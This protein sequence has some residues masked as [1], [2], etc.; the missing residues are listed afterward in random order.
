MKNSS[1]RVTFT[2]GL[3]ALA[4]CGAAAAQ[5]NETPVEYTPLITQLAPIQNS[6]AL[7]GG[8]GAIQ[9]GL[10]YTSQDNYMF[11]QYNGLSEDQPHFIGDLQ[12][13]D[14]QSN[15][16]YWQISLSDM[17]LDT[18][19]GELV[20]GKTDAL[21][22]SAAFDSQSQVRNDS[23]RTPF[24]G[25]DFQQLPGNWNSGLTTSD[26]SQLNDSLRR[27]DRELDRDTLSLAINARLDS[28]W[29]ARA[30]LSYEQKEGT[31]EVGAAIYVDGS[32]GDAVLLN[33]PIDYR[34]T[35]L[36]VGVAYSGSKLHLDGSL[37]YSDFDNRDDALL[38]QNPYSSFGP[39]VSYPAGIGGMGVAPDNEQ[40]SGRLTGS[41][42]F[43]PAVR[44]QFDGSYAL[45][46]QDQ[47]YS[48]YTAN[49]ALNVSTPLPQNS[50]DGE[51]ATSTANIKLL[52][53]PMKKMSAELF[54]RLRDRDYDAPRQGYLYVRGDGSDQ[55]SSALTVYN[56]THDLTSQTA[57]F[58]L[59]YRLPLRSKLSFEYAF[60]EVQRRNAAVETTEEDHYELGYR[61]QPWSNFSARLKLAYGDRAADTY[62]WD[63]SYYALLDAGL[64]NTTPDTQRYIN[65]PQFSQYYLANRERVESS[66]D[67]NYLPALAWNLNL[68]MQWR[69]DDYDATDLGLTGS[70]WQRL[71][72]SASYAATSSLSISA[73]AGYDEYE[74]DQVSRAF[75]GG[76]EKNAFA[77]YPPLPQASDPAQ[78]WSL[79]S[80]DASTTIG[81]NML[82]QASADLELALDYS[83]V[84]TRSEQAYSTDAAGS[85][86]ASDLPDVNTRLHQIEASGTL[87]LMESLSL[88]LEYQYYRYKSDDWAWDGVRPDTIAKVL[89]FGQRN[90]NEQIHYM[91]AS[92]I[93]RWQ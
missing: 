84:D 57:G 68:N 45:A 33:A 26:W 48:P 53:R 89:S 2:V 7:D 87:Q 17:G 49:T 86:V 14:F 27:F 35:T 42:I 22:I 63:Q 20:W 25:N 9:M 13:Q 37:A 44:L 3:V 36:N 47:S 69:D 18:R 75:R 11:G 10:G 93:Y 83:F 6:L 4:S 1:N 24:R 28:H 58:A 8:R 78:N 80:T 74:A 12:W 31:T 5:D 50:F 72:L 40:A 79:E 55:P 92:V 73:Y 61:I 38:W 54:Y 59:D 60:E 23:G 32:S 82:W 21:R 70:T 90:P 51:V 81:A 67:L 30:G 88:R 43:S 15:D 76:Q 46:M 77:I 64:I 52:T 56:T 65:H 19:E 91:G 29:E 62:Q 39:N 85:V 41:Y 34:T 71:H 66:I 16:S